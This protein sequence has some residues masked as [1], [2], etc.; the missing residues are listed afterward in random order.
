MYVR[1]EIILR[2]FNIEYKSINIELKSKK[3]LAFNINQFVNCLLI[4]L[5]NDNLSIII[6]SK[7]YK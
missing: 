3:N 4:Q 5:K 1:M 7:S 6:I 2:I